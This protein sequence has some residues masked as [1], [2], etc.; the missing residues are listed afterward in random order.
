MSSTLQDPRN[1]QRSAAKT[2]DSYF[3]PFDGRTLK[4]IHIPIDLSLEIPQP[5]KGCKSHFG[6]RQKAKAGKDSFWGKTFW[7][8]HSHPVR[9]LLP[10]RHHHQLSLPDCLVIVRNADMVSFSWQARSEVQ[11]GRYY[12]D[13]ACLCNFYVLDPSLA[14]QDISLQ[15]SPGRCGNKVYIVG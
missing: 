5:W 12:L 1:I 13:L 6:C 14:L 2:G 9:F 11:K 4:I 8:Q 3:F 10:H 7:Q 15:K